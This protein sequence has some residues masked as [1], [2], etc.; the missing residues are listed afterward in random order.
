[1][2]QTITQ[3]EK[4]NVMRRPLMKKT[5]VDPKFPYAHFSERALALLLNAACGQSAIHR[6]IREEL[7]RRWALGA[8]TKPVAPPGE[9][10]VLFTGA[11][12]DRDPSGAARQPATRTSNSGCSNYER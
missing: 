7:C 10:P 2:N 12:W 8:K 6:G 4:L 3:F 9:Q 5:E 11:E 1:M